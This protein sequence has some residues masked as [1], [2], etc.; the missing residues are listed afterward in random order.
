MGAC[1]AGNF[2]GIACAL[3]VLCTERTARAARWERGWTS[4][5]R[6]WFWVHDFCRGTRSTQ[7]CPDLAARAREIVDE[8]A[9][10]AW[11]ACTSIDLIPRW[12]SFWRDTDANSDVAA[13]DYGGER[14]LRRVVA[15]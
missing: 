5:R 9:L 4:V 12:I 2:C 13:D 3:C 11:A 10:V 15:K 6:G 7:T 8:G 14:H 1:F